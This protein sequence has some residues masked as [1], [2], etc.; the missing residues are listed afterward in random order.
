[1]TVERVLVTVCF[2]PDAAAPDFELPAFLPM[3]ELCPKLLETLRA[4]N[5]PKYAGVRGISMI[6][7]G[8]LLENEDTLASQGA[9][10][11]SILEIKELK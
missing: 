3:K 7:N 8:S 4:M 6:W 10:D 1:M 11:G 5:P 2:P 9:W